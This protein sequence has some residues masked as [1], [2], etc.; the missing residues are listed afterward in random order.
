MTWDSFSRR[1]KEK[2]KCSGL[3][4]IIENRTTV[5]GVKIKEQYS[6]LWFSTNSW[7]TLESNIAS[8]DFIFLI[9]KTGWNFELE[10]LISKVISSSNTLSVWGSNDK[11]QYVVICLQWSWFMPS[12]LVWLLTAH[13]HSQEYP[14]LDHKLYGHPTYNSY[15]NNFP[16]HLL[17]LFSTVQVLI[18]KVI[19]IFSW[20]TSLF[21]SRK[22]IIVIITALVF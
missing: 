17:R 12:V 6:R 13:F 14:G 8:L 15:Y 4:K 20:T 2:E 9:C 3:L 11:E 18:K 22:Q 5:T 19:E 7:V 21:S 16:S 10:I 1:N